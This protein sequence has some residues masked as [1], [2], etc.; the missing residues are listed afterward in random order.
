[1]KGTGNRRHRSTDHDHCDRDA[2]V[3]LVAA[4]VLVSDLAQLVTALVS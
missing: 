1:M 4:L 2:H 3:L